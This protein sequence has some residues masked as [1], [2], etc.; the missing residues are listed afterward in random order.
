[1]Q[2]WV[3]YDYAVKVPAPA[4]Q[5]SKKTEQGVTLATLLVPFKGEV[6]DVTVKAV[7][8]IHYEV[9]YNEAVY[10]ILLG[11]GHLQALADFEFDGDMLCAELDG[12]GTLVDCS[13]SQVSLIKYKEKTILDSTVRHKIDSHN[14][15]Q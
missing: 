13:G 9:T 14:S 10:L 5:Y 1:M 12:N 8:E 2:G 3:S 6:C 7:S 11:N 4:L 15:L